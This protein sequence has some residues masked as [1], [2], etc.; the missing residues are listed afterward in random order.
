MTTIADSREKSAQKAPPAAG[1]AARTIENIRRL[2]WLYL[3]LL[4]FEGALRKWAVPQFSAPLL[5]V[6]DPVALLIYALALQARVFPFNVYVVSIT[7]IAILSWA[8]GII[9]LSQVVAMKTVLLVT[10]YGVR[11]DFLHL[12][13]LFVIPAVMDLEDVK[14][15]GRWTIIGMIP[16]GLLMALQFNASPE[17]FLNRVAGAGEGLQLGSGGGKIRPPG[18]FSF[19][20]GAVYYLSAVAAFMLHAVLAKLPYKTWLLA[21]AGGA[22]LVGIGVSGSRSTVLSVGVVVA[23]LAVILLVRPS[24]VSKFGR[25][26][27][28]AAVVLWAISYVPV[29][30]EGLGILSDRFA[31]GAESSDSTV[32]GGL[33]ERI[34][35]GFAGGL[36]VLTR[37]PLGGFGLGVGTNG[38]ANFL[39]GH[40]EFLLAED[41]WP[42]I[43]LESGPIL[44]GAFLFWRCAITFRIGR[45][46]LRQLTHGNTLPLFLF[47]AAA[48]ALLQGP[49]GQP[50]SLGF[51][52]CLGALSLAAREPEA[53]EADPPD[54]S[55]ELPSAPRPV[56]RSVYAERLHGSRSGLHRSHGPFDR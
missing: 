28:L 38:G 19:V 34:L 27:L 7:V 21:A 47:S 26:I 45:L 39:I 52:I 13:L 41:E 5:I 1:D 44:G 24:L 35:S 20:S 15:I 25:Y 54:E 18:P 16:M 43:L 30:R 12:P 31:E 6:R 23:S 37:T 11:S 53:D 14:R 49:F 50:T 46:A 55:E 2:I 22:L 32:V 40:A 17:S 10:A 48:F 56:G 29:F 36:Q 3:F 42:R 33:A 51:A 8:A 4:I 9:V